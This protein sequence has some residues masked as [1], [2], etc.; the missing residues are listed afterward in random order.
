ME[1][2]PWY[3][4]A[5]TKTFITPICS[6]NLYFTN[7]LIMKDHCIGGNSFKVILALD[8]TSDNN[9]EFKLVAYDT[10]HCSILRNL[11]NVQIYQSIR[12]MFVFY[13]ER[14]LIMFI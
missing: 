1:E 3:N 6:L 8:L 7:T 9:K 4:L 11:G 10:L 5:F 14:V 12:F 2:T 13:G